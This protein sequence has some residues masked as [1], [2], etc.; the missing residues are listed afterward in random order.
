MPLAPLPRTGGLG[1]SSGAG[2]VVVCQYGS[3][4]ETVS[5][6]GHPAVGR[7]ALD[8]CQNQNSRLQRHAA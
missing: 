3:F 6:Q 8:Y 4:F 7:I 1:T 2:G 5:L